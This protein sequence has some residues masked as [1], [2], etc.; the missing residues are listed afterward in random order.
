MIYREF[1]IF[2]FNK[3][4]ISVEN[5]GYN[6]IYLIFFFSENKMVVDINPY[7]TASQYIWP[8]IMLMLWDKTK[9]VVLVLR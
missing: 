8:L 6:T 5:L 7:M 1:I 2:I 4:L 9:P 3:N